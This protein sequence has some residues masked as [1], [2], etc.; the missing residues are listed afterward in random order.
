[1]RILIAEDDRA[2]RL[3][4][5]LVFEDAGFEVAEA[6]DVSLLEEPLP[7]GI[8][9]VVVIDAGADGRGAAH[10]RELTIRPEWAGRALLM[11]GNVSVLGSMATHPDVFGKP[12]DYRVLVAR[13]AAI[14]PR[15]RTAAASMDADARSA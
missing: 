1:M 10:W 3:A 11:T 9:D 4:M 7:E 14:G 8:A 6:V 12:F 5:R 2:L 13:V 15:S